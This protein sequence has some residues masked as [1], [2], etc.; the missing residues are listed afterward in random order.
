MEDEKFIYNFKKI[1][2]RMDYCI[3]LIHAKEY[4]T[5]YKQCLSAYIELHLI[6]KDNP[7]LR[8]KYLKGIGDLRA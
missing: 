1:R 8:K 7:E 2:K 3:G 4:D 6:L 5:I